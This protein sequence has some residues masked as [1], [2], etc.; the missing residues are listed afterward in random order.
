MAGGPCTKS[1]SAAEGL[2]GSQTKVPKR[3]RAQA[4]SSFQSL[5]LEFRV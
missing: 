2:D 1:A 5:G 3:L 4:V